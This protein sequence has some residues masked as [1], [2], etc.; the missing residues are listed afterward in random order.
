M[1]TLTDLK[2]ALKDLFPSLPW[3]SGGAGREA[4]R[5]EL[6]LHS[7]W[8]YEKLLRE[9]VDS[10]F[11]CRKMVV[12][13]N[14]QILGKASD[15]WT[16]DSYVTLSEGYIRIPDDIHGISIYS[17]NAFRYPIGRFRVKLPDLTAASPGLFWGFE[18]GSNAGVHG[19]RWRYRAGAERLEAYC[20]TFMYVDITNLL[21]IGYDTTLSSYSVKVNRNLTELIVADNNPPLYTARY[22]AFGIHS[23]D[24]PFTP[25]PGPPY[26]LFGA[27]GT[28]VNIIPT[29]LIETGH[30]EL[31]MPPWGTIIADGVPC[32]PKILRLYDAGTNDLFAGLTI[33]AGSE[34][35][36]PFPVFG[37]ERKTINFRASEQ[38]T[39]SIEVLKETDNWREYDTM[40]ITQDTVKTYSIEGE[41][42]LARVV[43][44]P[45]TYPCDIDEAEV[46]LR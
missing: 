27:Q 29:S 36:H 23:L 16:Q 7:V 11:N 24:T 32:P 25:I 6:D 8:T 40:G 26:A 9:G 12:A 5:E 42:V 18:N 46:V 13:T 17:K 30:S 45:N 14:E 4:L 1:V 44:T 2:E 22:V 34:T 35:S 37:Y 41:A 43:F 21:P 31:Q 3:L 28:S 33:A 20:G 10:H 39:L 15:Y 19:F 38:G